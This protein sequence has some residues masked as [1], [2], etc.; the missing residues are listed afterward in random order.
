MAWANPLKLAFWHPTSGGWLTHGAAEGAKEGVFFAWVRCSDFGQRNASAG[1]HK[2]SD[3]E[4]DEAWCAFSASRFV[5]MNDYEGQRPF[6]PKVPKATSKKAIQDSGYTL[7]ARSREVLARKHRFW[8]RS[9]VCTVACP[10]VNS[11]SVGTERVA[12]LKA[13]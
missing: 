6:G 5:G 1:D 2:A 11:P 4:A 10:S 8:K 9:G 13:S 12:R 3:T 7:E